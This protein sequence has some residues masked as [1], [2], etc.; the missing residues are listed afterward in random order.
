MSSISAQYTWHPI[1]DVGHLLLE[2][3]RGRGDAKRIGHKSSNVQM[4]L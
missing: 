3:F 1:Q 2:V 4:G